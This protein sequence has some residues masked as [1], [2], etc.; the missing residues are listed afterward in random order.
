MLSHRLR[1]TLLTLSLIGGYVMANSPA[2]PAASVQAQG[3]R[4]SWKFDFGPG[5]VATDYRQVLA[6]TTY[7]KET[8]Y[9]FE[10]GAEVQ[11]ID[12]GGKDALRSDL[13]ASDKPFYFSVALPEGNYNVTV[14]FGDK[15]AETTATVKA[16]LRR[17][18]LEKVQTA[19]GKFETRTFTVNVRM[20]QISTGGQ[21]KLKEREKTMEIWN[22]DEKLTLE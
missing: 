13:C 17:L 8:G 2:N 1:V 6:T 19:P 21:V 11:C 15:T 18:M 12:R 7:S 5:R 16:E 4:T 3:N 22:W 20:P 14:T 10:P 9:G